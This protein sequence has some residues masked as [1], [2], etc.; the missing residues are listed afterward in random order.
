MLFD[1]SFVFVQ[2]VL[3]CFVQNMETKKY[4][5]TDEYEF[6]LSTGAAETTV[7][8]NIRKLPTVEEK[9]YIFRSIVSVLVI[10]PHK[11]NS[12]DGLVD[13]EEFKVIIESITKSELG[14]GVS[15]QTILICFKQIRKVKI[16]KKLCRMN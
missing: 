4:H 16:K 13:N 9:R 14:F 15:D 1:F 7:K 2:S 11:T 6:H 12:V 10:L 8:G 3:L 5:V